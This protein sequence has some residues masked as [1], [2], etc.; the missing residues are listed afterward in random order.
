MR[1]CTKDYKV[2]DTDFTIRKGMTIN[3]LSGC[4]A[5]ECFFNPAELDPD[6]FDTKNN[7]NK[8]GFAG[9]GNGPRNCIGMRYAYIALKLALV[10][11]ITKYKVVK[12]EKT[13]DKLKFDISKNYFNG[14]VCFKV[15]RLEKEE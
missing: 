8:F 4:F 1:L 9:F 13:V 12:C 11:T 2:P 6:N 3:V 10:K 5:E 14:G 15:E 7:P